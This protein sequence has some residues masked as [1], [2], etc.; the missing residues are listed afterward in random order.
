MTPR[1]IHLVGRQGCGKTT[2]GK[3]IVMGLTAHGTRA[4]AEDSEISSALSND[5][6]RKKFADYEVVVVEAQQRGVRHQPPELGLTDTVLTFSRTE[7]FAGTPATHFTRTVPTCVDCKFQVKHADQR[8][9]NHPASP[10]NLTDGLPVH[11]ALMMRSYGLDNPELTGC[12]PS[13][14]LFEACTDATASHQPTAAAPTTPPPIGHPWPGIE[15]SAYAGVSRGEDGQPEA[16]LVLL[17]DLPATKLNWKAAQTW[18]DSVGGQLPTRRESALLYAQL[19]EKID[20]DD[21]WYWSG[22]QYS[23]AVAWYQLF[24]GGFQNFNYK[25][26]EARARAVRRFTA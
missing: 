2:L 17:R 4:A 14:A 15:G 20:A 25:K 24:N 12:G 26:Y 10:I 16:H 18:A 1:L 23:D 9:C 5:Q 19:F 7:A 3:T 6:I 13:G 21:G 11:S 8:L 22:T